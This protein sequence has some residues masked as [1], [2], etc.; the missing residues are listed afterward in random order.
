[1]EIQRTRFLLVAN[2][3]VPEAAAKLGIRVAGMTFFWSSDHRR[4]ATRIGPYA[5]VIAFNRTLK[6]P[7]DSTLPGSWEIHPVDLF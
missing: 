4:P 7:D 3:G 2:W 5:Y 1:M 6:L